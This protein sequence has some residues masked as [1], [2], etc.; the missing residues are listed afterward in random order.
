MSK[1]VLLINPWIYDF[2]AYDFWMKP[3]GLL[4]IAAY[5]RKAGFEINFIDCLDR[6]H[7]VLMKNVSKLPKNDMFGRGKFYTQEIEKPAVYQHITRKY[8]R[9]GMPPEVFKQI[10]D[11]VCEPDSILVT[12][13]MTYWYPGLFDVIKILKTRFPK[14]PV[15]L[16]GIYATICYEHAREF[17]R[18]DYVI[19]GP[20][21]Q[22]LVSIFPELAPVSFEHLPFPAF[23]LY[24]G[25]DYACILTSQGCPFS[26]VY[27]AVPNLSL[28]LIY[29]DCASIIS[30]IIN[31]QNMGIKNIA[32]Y[33]D[34]LLTNPSFPLVLDE[35]IKRNIKM[36][37]HTP[38]GLHPRFFNQELANKMFA[39]GFK[40]IYLSLETIDYKIHEKIDNKVTLQEF[41][42]A[43][44]YLKKGEFSNSQIHAYLMIGLPEISAELV[45]Q[46]IDFVH[47][48]GITVHLVEFSPIPGTKAFEQLGFDEQTDPC[49]HNN[50]IFPALN[51]EMKKEMLEL[52]AYLSKLQ[53]TV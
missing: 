13:I 1:K 49:L 19:K 43:F 18:A 39:A 21:E 33:D 46:S 10:L 6:Y 23:D 7:P 36:Q 3:L 16:G 32:F 53:A 12:S 52:K 48:L 4:Y 5:L 8:R 41:V 50:T 31:Y 17:S 22:N 14:T 25:L 42:Q 28:K 27:C 35:I 47:S 37:F 44:K 40:T 20:A 2:K 51:D 38:N 11:G 15:I 30:E 24:S 29:R 9:Y 45:K 34:A 26:C